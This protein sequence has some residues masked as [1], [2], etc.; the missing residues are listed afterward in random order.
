MLE[1]ELWSKVLVILEEKIKR[2]NLL[3]WFKNTAIL[4]VE[5]GVMTVGLPLPM[6]LDWHVSHYMKNTLEAA[7][8][9]EPTIQNIAYLV[10]TALNEKD[11]RV[12]DIHQF[13][14][15][16]SRKLPNKREIRLPGGII[17]KMFNP[18]YRLG[19]FIIGPEN[20]LAHA[21]SVTVAKY[22]GE[23]Y[24][25]LFVY[26]GV[27]LGK[28]HLLQG[29]GNAMLENDPNRIVMYTTTEAFTNEVID[30]IQS[31][32]MNRFRNRYRK[33]DALIIDDIQFIFNK[34]RTQEEFFHTFNTL[35]DAGKQVIISSD[36][37]PHELS[38]LSERLISRFESGMIV[39]VKMPDLETRMAIL[40]NKCQEAQ[41]L[42]SR[43]VIEFI[44]FNIS[45]SVRALEGILQR[46][47]AQY[48]LEHTTPTI[49]SV[50]EII[51]QT[52]KEVKLSNY[53]ERQDA[54]P[55]YAISVDDL[56]QR[57]SDYY[58]VPKSEVIGEARN[59]EYMIPRQVIMYLAK[60]KLKISLAKIGESMG[61][62]NHTTVMHAVER[63]VNQ[64]KNDRQLLRDLNAIKEETGIS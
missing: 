2:P 7:K 20:R 39:D 56:I 54:Q 40:Q 49:R 62:R 61:N 35:F 17:S 47:I 53:I 64:L 48:E 16:T 45:H 36:R 34:D 57:V 25:P 32:D 30:C 23:N 22:P 33:V 14:E 18:R 42:I 55:K 9:L 10:D 21:A 26:G 12:I 41:V 58:Q 51:K 19:N 27:G 13:S 63:I 60:T 1:K 29:I 52:Q 8:T 4:S 44:A 24:N 43:E 50:T 6:F 46:V 5:N 15:K 31:R 38:L 3:T 59:R 37:P 11:T 28:T